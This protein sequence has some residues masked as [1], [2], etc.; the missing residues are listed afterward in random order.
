[1]IPARKAGLA[2]KLGH[3]G[4]L[5]LTYDISKCPTGHLLSTSQAR[6][7]IKADFGLWTVVY[8]AGDAADAADAPVRQLAAALSAAFSDIHKHF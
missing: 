5:V 7:Q 4:D 6:E 8:G 2:Q 1:M 3:P